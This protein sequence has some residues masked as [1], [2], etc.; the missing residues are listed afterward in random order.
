[1]KSPIFDIEHLQL[2]CPPTARRLL[3]LA[4]FR[5]IRVSAL[6]NAYPIHYWVKLL[7]LP[8]GPK[9]ALLRHMKESPLGRVLA[10][11]PAGNLICIGFK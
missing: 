9:R 10:P 2:F 1:M 7:P 3:G 6:W 4:G 11:L 8:A 5:D